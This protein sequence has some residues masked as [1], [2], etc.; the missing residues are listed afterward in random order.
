MI[1]SKK[2]NT[3]FFLIIA[4]LLCLPPFFEGGNSPYILSVVFILVSILII[5]FSLNLDKKEDVS[6]KWYKNPIFYLGLFL[7]FIFISNFFSHNIYFS[8]LYFLQYLMF[9]AL[10]FIISKYSFSQNSVKFLF[11]Y[12][13]AVSLLLCLVGIFFYLNSSSERIGSTFYQP[14]SFAGYLLFALPLAFLFLFQAERKTEKTLFILITIIL[15]ST[16][17]LTNSRGAYL[18]FLPP[19]IL[20]LILGFYFFNRKDILKK[21]ILVFVGSFIFVNLLYSLNIGKLSFFSIF[22]RG[23]VPGMPE[24]GVDFSTFTRFKFWEGSVE[25]FKEYPVLGAGL[26]SFAD[27]YP[28]YQ[29]SAVAFTKYPHNHYLE[30][31]CETGILGTI[32]FWGLV[33]LLIYF[34]FQIFRQCIINKTKTDKNKKLLIPCVLF[35]CVLG[36]I[37]HNGVDFD[38]HFL[39]NF[40][41]FFVFSGLFYNISLGVLNNKN[42]K[43]RQNKN[44][45]SSIISF[46]QKKQKYF[47]FLLSI[48][49]I[50]FSFS[51]TM[52]TFYFNRG[53]E[54]E[55]N[56]EYKSALINFQKGL[57][58]NPNPDYYLKEGILFYSFGDLDSAEKIG[59]KLIKIKKSDADNWRFLAKIREARGDLNSAEIFYQKAIECD[60][61]FI[62]AY[63]DIAN[64]YFKDKQYQKALGVLDNAISKYKDDE[65][66]YFKGRRKMYSNAIGVEEI[67]FNDTQVD[68]IA[69]L[70]KTKGKFL[71]ALGNKQEGEKYIL[72]SQE[73]LA[74]L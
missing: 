74:P 22:E 66:Q 32:F 53:D 37:L 48:L 40:L 9:F 49:F 58:V 70:Y 67:Y 30:I 24:V 69:L 43:G 47:Y 12:F 72:K 16:F 18:S 28:R 5:I 21:I 52:G 34:G 73:I 2:Q 55:L 46:F 20:L 33:F 14:N 54:L 23:K 57:R 7:I 71:N 1:K 51:F 50:I 59:L 25:I 3:I 45:K 15:L 42:A 10:F 60:P 11:Y 64:L 35:C 41:I 19:F 36:S 44:I 17:I 29:Y 56:Q 27:L 62:V 63:I 61:Y 8:W 26:G 31:L 6:I 39:A 38:W 4:I 65:I 13:L 68:E